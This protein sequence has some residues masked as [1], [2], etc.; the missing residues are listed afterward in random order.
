[1]V[2]GTAGCGCNSHLDVNT[3]RGAVRGGTKAPAQVPFPSANDC[4]ELYPPLRILSFVRKGAI[5]IRLDSRFWCVVCCCNGHCDAGANQ[6]SGRC[7]QLGR[8][9]GVWSGLDCRL[10]GLHIKR[11]G[12]GEPPH[13]VRFAE[14]NVG[15]EERRRG[16]D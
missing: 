13:N 2:V 5:S 6:K 14:Q 1:M 10:Q 16:L 8:S 7:S 9:W 12:W 4:W 11:Q 3:R 15:H